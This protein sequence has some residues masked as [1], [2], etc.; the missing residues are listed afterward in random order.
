MTKQRPGGPTIEG[1]STLHEGSREGLHAWGTQIRPVWPEGRGGGGS[2]H[3]RGLENSEASGPCRVFVARLQ[4]GIP[5]LTEYVSCLTC[6]TFSSLPSFLLSQLFIER[7]NNR[8]K[9]RIT[10]AAVSSGLRVGYGPSG[11]MR[12]AH[13][14]VITGQEC[15][16]DAE[17]RCSGSF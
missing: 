15:H 4:K 9:R 11:G 12:T 8:D 1:K 14:A 3:R 7:L 13:R 16:A 17:H 5:N 2:W 6:L 10:A